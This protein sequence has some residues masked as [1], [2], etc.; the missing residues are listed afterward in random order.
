MVVLMMGVMK[1]LFPVKQQS[2]L[3]LE[4]ALK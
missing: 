4:A 3:P 1:A 2:G